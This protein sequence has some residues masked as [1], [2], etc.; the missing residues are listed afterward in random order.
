[1]SILG[2]PAHSRSAGRVVG[3]SHM[4]THEA[5]RFADHQGMSAGWLLAEGAQPQLERVRQGTPLGVSLVELFADSRVVKT[6]GLASGSLI[7]V[8]AALHRGQPPSDRSLT[9]WADEN[10]HPWVEVVD[11]EVAYW[12]NLTDAQIDR[13]LALFIARRPM[14]GDWR[15]AEWNAK[16]ATRV[17]KGLFE[18]G[19]TR[20]LDLARK[21]PYPQCDLWGGIHR[22]SIIDHVG[23]PLPSQVQAGIRVAAESDA[24]N[25]KDLP[26]DALLLSD[27]TGKLTHDSGVAN[28]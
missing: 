9:V 5:L 7:F 22:L 16:A 23:R 11:N 6:E 12:G 15:S 14:D 21:K 13:L 17:R 1:M 20:N 2:Y 19:W 4:S 10:N 26:A 18:H 28:S 25:I 24:W 27:E 3:I 8:A